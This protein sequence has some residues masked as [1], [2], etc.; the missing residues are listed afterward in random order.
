MTEQER[1]PSFEERVEGFG[2]DAQAAGERFGRQ[3]EAAG[4]RLA[5]DPSIQTATDTAARAWGL[6][7]IAVGAWFFAQVTLGY[8]LPAIPWRD[9]WPVG[10]ILIGLVIVFR[11][12]GRR[13][14]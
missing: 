14:A 6:L 11:G 9:L 4:R 8:D 12:M 7:L 1:P 5:N 3:A 10:L 2:R 13:R